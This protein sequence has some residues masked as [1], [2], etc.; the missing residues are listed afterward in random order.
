VLTYRAPLADVRFLL[1]HVLE[2]EPHC[3]DLT[4]VTVPDAEELESILA[5]AAAF[6]EREL[7]PLNQPGDSVG[8]R[9]DSGQVSTPEGFERAYGLYRD[10][11]WSGLSRPTEWGGSGLPPSL[12][13]VVGEFFAT[14]NWSWSMYPGLAHGAMDT[15]ETFGSASQKARYLQPLVSGRWAATMCLTEP[16]C[17]SDLAQVTSRARQDEHGDWR[18]TGTKVFIT[19]G[20]HDLTENIVHIVLARLPDA[21]AGTRGLSLFVV[22]KFCVG[23]DGQPDAR[24]TVSCD[25]IEDK[26]GLKASATC[27]LQFCDARAEL[28]GP[29]HQGLACMFVFMNAAR[30]AAGQQGVAHAELGLQNALSYTLERRAMSAPGAGRT[31]GQVADPIIEH[32]DVRR[33]LLEQRV[34]AEGG[35]ALVAYAGCHIDR[36][37]CSAQK[38]VRERSETRLALLTPIIKGTLT[39]LGFE[40]ASLAVQCLGAYGYVRGSGLEQNLRDARIATIYEGTTGIQALDLL[41]R[42]VVRDE[43]R[44]LQD[45]LWELETLCASC[46]GIDALQKESSQLR[47]ECAR[48]LAC[49]QE[50]RRR[51]ADDPRAVASAATEY[52]MYSGYLALA[53]VW[54]LMARK[55]HERLADSTGD[56]FLSG[57]IE[58]A[59]FFFS[60]MFPRCVALRL[61]MLADPE[62]LEARDA[63]P[64][65]PPG[66]SISPSS[67]RRL[68]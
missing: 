10:G 5:T 39:E 2:Y 8:C 25:G 50:L 21:P 27:T 60:R 22:P 24:N 23:E 63:L 18:L 30:V 48:W 17:G 33:M 1:D 32:P 41:G 52:L 31:S 3:Q 19:G 47:E 12:S 34:I 35:R 53:H 54:L 20:E 65:P 51:A 15:L 4:G 16:Q 28:L 43:L 7:L 55:A 29:P 40:A 68:A 67:D 37:A 13:L 14:A 58:T 38:E 11:G 59:K 46:D 61:S 44:A 26:L 49:S 56:A 64:T 9:F 36:S 57:K 62:T 6:S 42:K 45:Y 66:R